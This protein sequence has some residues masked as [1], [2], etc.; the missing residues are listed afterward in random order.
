MLHAL[1]ALTALAPFTVDDPALSDGLFGGTPGSLGVPTL[2]FDGAPIVGRPFVMRVTDALPGS[3]AVVGASA[4]VTPVPIPGTSGTLHLGLPLFAFEIE[5]IGVDGRSTPFLPVPNVAP[6]LVGVEF[7]AQG[8]VFD[9]SAVGSFAYTNGL[10]VRIGEEPVRSLFQ[11]QRVLGV[12]D[13]SNCL[14][15]DLDQD[16]VAD[17]VGAATTYDGIAVHYGLGGGA[18]EPFV[19]IALAS[20]PRGLEVADL[21]ADGELDLVVAGNASDGVDVLLGAGG[22]AFGAATNHSTGTSTWCVHAADVDGDGLVDLVAGSGS[23]LY[24]V[25]VVLGNG[26]GTFGAPTIVPVGS[27]PR[28]LAL[29]DLDTDGALD[30]VVANAFSDDVSVLLGNGD[31]TFRSEQTLAAG[32]VPVLAGVTDLDADGILDLIVDEIGDDQVS[33][34]VGVGDGTFVPASSQSVPG[35]VAASVIDLQDDGSSDLAVMTYAGLA[36]SH[37]LGNAAFGLPDPVAEGSFPHVLSIG[38]LNG[39]GSQDALFGSANMG[40]SVQL[41]VSPGSF[42]APWP[43]SEVTAPT[44]SVSACEL[45]DLDRDGRLDLVV[46]SFDGQQV[47]VFTGD[48]TGQFVLDQ[49]L[50]VQADSL[51]LGDMDGDGLVDIVAG[52]WQDD[53]VTVLTADGSGVLSVGSTF[54]LDFELRFQVAD[55]DSDGVLDLVGSSGYRAGDGVGGFGGYVDLA[56]GVDSTSMRFADV[57][58]DGLQDLVHCGYDAVLDQQVLVVR[59]GTTGGGY[60]AGTSYSTSG[61]GIYGLDVADIDRDG[62]LDLV[63]GPVSGAPIARMGS[64]DGSF[65]PEV[66]VAPATMAGYSIVASDVDGDRVVDLVTYGNFGVD[67]SIGAGDGT[68]ELVGRFVRTSGLTGPLLVDD[69]DG[70][71][72]PDIVARGSDDDS[73]LAIRLNILVD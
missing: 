21:N 7:Y 37:G 10:R 46:A 49:T 32:S 72:L 9:P 26:D 73:V 42:A 69:V 40:A 54:T 43:A 4:T 19:H 16:G 22:R 58:A 44:G 63:L 17:L 55:V 5:T 45:L 59:I 33:T 24:D 2:T 41:Q 38:D 67:V 70:N 31:G 61:F 62:N 53:T 34:W 51:A 3:V 27:S 50:A 18:Y 56:S 30:L 66:V 6:N 25:T 71:G 36:M 23:S 64:G 12:G 28:S 11:G 60:A 14:I 57:D 1:L 35:L 48:G 29:I 39:D 13:P 52:A 68:F 15:V 20:Y 47:H 8:A 65:G